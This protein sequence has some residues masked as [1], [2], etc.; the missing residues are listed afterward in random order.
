[1]KIVLPIS[2]LI[3][4]FATSLVVPI[5]MLVVLCWV[6]PLINPE[7]TDCGFS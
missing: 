3:R 7:A 1:M 5:R 4:F 6:R 2:S